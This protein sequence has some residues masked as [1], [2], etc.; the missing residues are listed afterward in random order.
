MCLPRL[1]SLI[2]AALLLL[3]PSTALAQEKPLL[4]FTAA[5]TTDAISRVGQAFSQ[6]TGFKVVYSFAASSTLAKQV[7]H[8]APAEVFISANHKWMD[9][10][11][12]RKMIVS[13]TRVEILRNTLVF[14]APANSKLEPFKIER[15]LDLGDALGQ[16]RLALGDPAHVPAGMYAKEALANLGLWES[17]K[18][19]IA[20]AATVRGA[21]ALVERGEAPL[22]VVYATDAE[23]SPKVKVM[24]VFSAAS[25]SPISY[26]A[27]IVAGRD[28]PR[29]RAYLE[30]LGS[31]QAKR[32]FQQHGFLVE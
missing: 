2:I 29:A 10:L 24:G 28:S 26:P 27:A 32:I 31:P 12:G 17:I 25:H 4:V 1:W 23:I 19:R 15:A 14:I 11:A 16:G 7:I 21:L 8:G 13:A 20:A 30:F 22:G 5:S 18:N 3:A 9:Y 6:K